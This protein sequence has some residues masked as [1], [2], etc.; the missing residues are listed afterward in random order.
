MEIEKIGLGG[1]CHWC[2]EA[3]FQ[4]IEGI[5]KVAQ[6]WIGSTGEHQTLSEGVLVY[7][8]PQRTSLDDI[9]QTHLRT[10]SSTSSHGM[11]EKYRSAVYIFEDAHRK[12]AE[13][14][15]NEYEAEILKRVITLILPF[16]EFKLNDATY[17][18]YYRKNPA[19][20]FCQRYIKPKL[21]QLN[22]KK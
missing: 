18:D 22:S 2:T 7:F 8:E 12:V 14:A 10:H 3:V 16:S 5:Q 4:S 13:K 1:G 6:G 19:K 15:I 17:L 21:E 20:A 9:I 11:R